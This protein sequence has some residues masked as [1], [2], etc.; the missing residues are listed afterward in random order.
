MQ[1]KKN[2]QVN[3]HA[4][5]EVAKQI[6]AR[7]LGLCAT[8]QEQFRIGY[9]GGRSKEQFSRSKEQQFSRSKEPNNLA[10]PKNNLGLDTQEAGPTMPGP[11]VSKFAENT[12]YTQYIYGSGQPYRCAMICTKALIVTW[13]YVE[14]GKTGKEKTTRA[15][16]TTSQ[17][18][19]RYISYV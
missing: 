17:L 19:G 9:A 5:E 10:G 1:P 2:V 3:S 13:S 6:K 18:I 14:E 15:G 4:C 12:V 11:Y 16:Q 8:L 7:T